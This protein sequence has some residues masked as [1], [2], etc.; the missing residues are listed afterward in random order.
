MGER[1][2]DF[3]ILGVAMV[4][5]IPVAIWIARDAKKLGMRK[6]GLPEASIVDF[7]PAGW[8]FCTILLFAVAV[9]LYFAVARPAYQKRSG[10]TS[11]S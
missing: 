6:G 8:F 9:P 3:V 7:G 10:R 5:M 2:I 11:S 4:V 1:S